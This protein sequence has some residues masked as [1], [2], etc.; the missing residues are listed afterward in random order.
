MKD[1]KLE[2]RLVS[3]PNTDKPILWLYGNMVEMERDF[4][5]TYKGSISKG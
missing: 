5:S 4:T 1:K 2:F 3:L